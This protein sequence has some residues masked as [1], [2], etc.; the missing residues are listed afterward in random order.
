MA[1]AKQTAFAYSALTGPT[2]ATS[3]PAMPAPS[4]DAVRC[5]VACAPVAR[6]MGVWASSTTSGSWA[7]RAVDP[8]VSSRLLRKTRASSSGNGSMPEPGEHRDGEHGQAARGVR[9]D[10][11][12][13]PAEAVDQ[14][15]AEGA[16]DDDRHGREHAGEPG[17]ERGSG[18]RQH[19]ERHGDRRDRIA[20]ARDAVGREQADQGRAAAGTTGEAL[21]GHG[22]RN[23][24]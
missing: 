19:V 1:I 17:G 10:A 15:A 7:T 9:D 5:T 21:D 3:V 14:H 6:V 2:R 16:A 18:E 11:R 23:D 4:I 20:G 24:E 22:W 12:A 8:G 13:P